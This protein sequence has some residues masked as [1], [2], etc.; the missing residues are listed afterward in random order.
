[1]KTQVFYFPRMV[2]R[3]F[4]ENNYFSFSLYECHANFTQRIIST[5]HVN[6]PHRCVLFVVL[7][8]GISAVVPPDS[9]QA[10][11]QHTGCSEPT[12]H[13]GRAEVVSP[14]S[15]QPPGAAHSGP[16]PRHIRRHSKAF[17]GIRQFGVCS[18]TAKHRR[19]LGIH[20]NRVLSV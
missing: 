18:H 10:A 11:Q 8:S 5:G 16:K 13:T 17:E 12:F 19:E 9:Q 15:E 14:S 6:V 4:Q 7:S 2:F 1:M 20:C 3:S